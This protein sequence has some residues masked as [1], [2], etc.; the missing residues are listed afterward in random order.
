MVRREK[1]I[2]A[3]TVAKS[4]TN[5]SNAKTLGAYIIIKKDPIKIIRDN[6]DEAKK[7]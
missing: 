2:M 7:H 4:G 6:Y 1:E 3:D 5:D